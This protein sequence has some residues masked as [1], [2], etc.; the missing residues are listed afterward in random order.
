MPP[1]PSCGCARPAE[2]LRIFSHASFLARALAG[3]TSTL[4]FTYKV[5]ATGQGTADLKVTGIKLPTAGAIQDL[6]GNTAVLGG[7]AK[8]LAIALATGETSATATISGT[9]VL[10]LF[11][12]LSPATSVTQNVTFAALAKGALQIDDCGTFAGQVAG[13]T[14]AD[15]LDFADLAYDPALIASYDAG[16]SLLTVDDGL[17]HALASFTLTAGA[18]T[19][20]GTATM[21]LS[22]DPHGGTTLKIV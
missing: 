12:P 6:A 10:E 5:P 19:N 18:A 8:D 22:D 4:V 11:G 1:S 15:A 17:G 16:S 14:S 20:L 2:D 7:G 13:F 21:H 3:R 9:Q